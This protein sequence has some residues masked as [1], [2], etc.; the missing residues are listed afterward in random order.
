MSQKR[1]RILFELLKKSADSGQQLTIKEIL[2]ATGWQSSTF[3]TYV[4]KKLFDVISCNN[5]GTITVC[6]E[7]PY[8]RDE[9]TFLNMMSQVKQ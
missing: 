5:D 6:A 8:L 9:E 1:Q 4:N 3:E 7:S 2:E